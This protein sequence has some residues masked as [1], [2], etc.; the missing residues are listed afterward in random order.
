M[1]T[2]SILNTCGKMAER[3]SKTLFVR[4]LPFTT[5]NTE[6]T[7]AFEDVGPVKTAFVVADRGMIHRSKTGILFCDSQTGSV[8]AARETYSRFQTR[9]ILTIARILVNYTKVDSNDTYFELWTKQ[10]V[11]V[12]YSLGGKY[13]LDCLLFCGSGGCGIALACDCHDKS[14]WSRNL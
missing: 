13:P 1:C 11:A 2:G 3:K 6:L 9:R 12:Y 5:S 10:K 14:L 8:T 7:K 4:N